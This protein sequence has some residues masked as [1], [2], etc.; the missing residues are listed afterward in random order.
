MG[1]NVEEWVPIAG[2]EGL[3]EISDQGRVRSLDYRCTGRIQVLKPGMYGGGYLQVG[4][5]KNGKRE[6]YKVH[7]LVAEAFLANAEGLPEVNHRDENKQNNCVDNLEWCD[8]RHNI[9]HGTRTARQA[10][11]KSK[12]VQQFSKDGRLIAVW[13]SA[14]EA[15]QAT[16]VHQSHINQCCNGRPHYHTAGGYVWKYA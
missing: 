10:A 11:A 1:Q 9:N 7:R 6:H 15:E 12:P 3:Y 5:C 2:Y 13:P 16:G 8:R 4:L 14:T